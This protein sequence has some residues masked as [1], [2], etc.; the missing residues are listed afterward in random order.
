MAKSNEELIE[1]ISQQGNSE[2]LQP[3]NQ[4]SNGQRIVR[5]FGSWVQKTQNQYSERMMTLMGT[6]KEQD[7]IR[8]FEG[9]RE[10]ANANPDLMICTPQS[11]RTCFI[12]SAET[13][14]IPGAFQE[15]AYVP[16]YNK[17]IKRKEAV[18]IPMYRGLVRLM[19]QGGFVKSL[20][21][22][23]VY[24]N[25][26]FAFERGTNQFLR[27][28]PVFENRGKRICVWVV[29][30]TVHDDFVM[31]VLSMK[32]INQIKAKSK[33]AKSGQSPWNEDNEIGFDAMAFKTAL[34]Q[35]DKV[36]PSSTDNRYGQALNKAVYYDNEDSAGVS[37]P[38]ISSSD[39]G[40]SVM[41]SQEKNQR[42]RDPE[43]TEGI[44]EIVPEVQHALPDYEGEILEEELPEIEP[45]TE[46]QQH[47]KKA[48]EM[49]V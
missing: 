15:C 3:E 19:Y 2:S 35:I 26:E 48:S 42:T 31:N 39:S 46:V 24:E 1:K 30:K 4:E 49:N 44:P 7:V 32:F 9:F 16:F 27:H 23:V 8:I 12:K 6:E 25:D 37:K 47:L 20:N 28:V 11:L 22:A 38:A 13:T 45:A 33:A 41:Y 18:W 17:S 40:I 43:A 5:E 14:L 10:Q 36:I 21:A 29:A 34:R